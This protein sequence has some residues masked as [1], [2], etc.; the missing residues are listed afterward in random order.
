MERPTFRQLLAVQAVA[1][2]LVWASCVGSFV[3]QSSD[4][5]ERF[6][7]LARGPY[8]GFAVLAQLRVLPA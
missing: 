6:A 1:C 4:V 2:G 7:A 5:A 3:G 8:L